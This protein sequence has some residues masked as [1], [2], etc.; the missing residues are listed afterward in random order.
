MDGGSLH[1][2]HTLLLNCPDDFLP[3]SVDKWK[4]GQT[5]VGRPGL[6]AAAEA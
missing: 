6:Q 4:W 3:R 5:A 2:Y 1:V